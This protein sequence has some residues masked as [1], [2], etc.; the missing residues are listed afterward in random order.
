MP[1]VL[2]K[3]TLR[4]ET[5]RKDIDDIVTDVDNN[6]ATLDHG[7]LVGYQQMLNDHLQS[8]TAF[9]NDI[10][11]EYEAA[12]K[13]DTF[14][15]QECS[16]SN[17]YQHK[18]KKAQGIITV[19]LNAF[20]SQINTSFQANT[21]ITS[22][23]ARVSM[24]FPE[25]P[26]PSFSG[27]ET[28]SLDDFFNNLESTLAITTA[29]PHETFLLLKQS[30]S[31][32]AQKLISSVRVSNTAYDDAK[33]I[34][35]EAYAPSS[36]QK[37]QILENFIASRLTFKDHIFDH[38]S[39]MQDLCDAFDR[40]QIDGEFMKQ[41]FLWRSFNGPLQE[42][43]TTVTGKYRPSF[44]K[45]QKHKYEAAERYKDRQANFAEKQK[46]QAQK[47]AQNSPKLSSGL[48]NDG[49]ERLSTFAAN[50]PK[51][52]KPAWC[53]LC[54]NTK[55][56]NEHKMYNCPQFVTAKQKVDRL[57][58]IHGCIKCGYSNH[59]K[60]SCK[61]QFKRKCKHCNSS[62]L[63]C[64]C[65]RSET[66]CAAADP[67]SDEES[68]C[69]PNPDTETENESESDGETANMC[70]ANF[71]ASI[72]SNSILP[73][74]AVKVNGKTFRSLRDNGCQKNL[75]SMNLIKKASI[76]PFKDVSIT[77][78]GFNSSKKYNTK[79]AFIPLEFGREVFIIEVVIL[80]E[81]TVKFMAKSIK[82][83]A[84]EFE[85][86]GYRLA[87]PELA[88]QN[89]LVENLDLVLG[90][91]TVNIFE[92]KTVTFG[93]NHGSAYF[94]SRAGI[95]PVGSS[96]RMINDLEHLPCINSNNSNTPSKKAKQKT[97][98]LTSVNVSSANKGKSEIKNEVEDVR[99]DGRTC[100]SDL[101][102]LLNQTVGYDPEH[103]N[104][105]FSELDEH[106]TSY[107]LDRT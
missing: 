81:V 80:P 17:S 20:Q 3:L 48:K 91:D 96:L 25:V 28:E 82:Q 101:Q 16:E 66:A 86:K 74:V 61:F 9:D 55:Q 37:Y 52:D 27:K 67:S 83:I 10:F 49:R 29:Q 77:I 42:A 41:F 45:I 63:S 18:I 72:S 8:I 75:A 38:Y 62:H 60:S 65:L 39:H 33:K 99:L 34:L 6:S 35:Q 103:Y 47:F 106:L 102:Y 23:I 78:N 57:E 88:S 4:R 22:N 93:N 26:M 98:N 21:S 44:Q 84:K 71:P 14:L 76:K 69:E 36:K 105:Q 19:L 95:M 85:N 73:T 53:A 59:Q 54:S 51:A 15:A 58:T 94:E 92:E 100:E 11:D 107:V 40:A 2:R 31:G 43:F 104:D 68:N 70:S 46:R 30:L 50:V 90:V 12:G 1:A 97:S 64:L 32:E 79:A 89:D 24:K 13:D 87:D 5:M 7:T 56:N